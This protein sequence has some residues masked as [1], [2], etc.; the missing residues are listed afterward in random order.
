M[1]FDL[2]GDFEDGWKEAIC[3]SNAL[4]LQREVP[5]EVNIRAA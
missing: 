5:E 3:Q 1:A 2:S 4:L